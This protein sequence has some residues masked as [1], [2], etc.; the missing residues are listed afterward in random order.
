LHWA[1][2]RVRT[3]AVIDTSV[4]CGGRRLEML[5][6][7]PLTILDATPPEQVSAAAAAGFD[8]LGIRVYPV[9]DERV[10]PMLGD[11][12]MMRETLARLAA[13]GRQV[14]DVEL[15]ILRPTGLTDDALRVLDAGARMGARF[16][17][18][19]GY[20]RDE[21]RLIDSFAH[22]CEAAVER[23]IRPS[24]EFMM[25]SAVK[26]VHDALRIVERAEHPSGAVLVDAL[27]LR[28]S[29]GSPADLATM[30]PQRLPYAQLCDAPLEPVWPDE[31]EA[32]TESRTGRLLLGDGELPLHELMDVL[33]VGAALSVETPVA[34]LAGKPA[35]ERARLAFAAAAGLL[36]RSVESTEDPHG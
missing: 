8:A 31:D 29:G 17:Q 15:I 36:D 10:S 35:A 12:P 23:G 6:L 16:V 13:T 28:R 7:S 22:V 1:E 19:L 25:Y 5:S 26:T 21:D 34:V 4:H 20:D 9:A 33:P 27:H 14:L 3:V 24:L 2:V 18:V 32:R 30:P 11:T